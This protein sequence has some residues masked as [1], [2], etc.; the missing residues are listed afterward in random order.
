MKKVAIIGVGC[1]KFGVR[2]DVNVAELAFEAFKPS[3]EDA[4]ITPKEIEF[5]AVGSTGAGAWYEELLPAVVSAEYCGLTGAGLIRCEAACASGSAAFSTAYWAVASGQVE[6]AAALGIEKMRE[7][8]TPTMMEWIGRAGYYL[9][10]F[11]NFGL[12]FPA[13]YALYATAH[14]AKY[15]TTEEDLA[16]VAVKNHKYA[17]MNPIAHLQ[18]R[19]IVDDVL[20]S[21]VIAAPLKLFDCCPVSDGAASVILASEDKVKELKVDTPVWVAGVGFA[22]GTANM[23]KRLDYVGLEASVQASQKAYKMAKITPDQLDVAVVHDCFTIAEIMAYEDIGLCEKGEG[24]KL[25]REGQTEI[26]GKIPVN[27]DGGLKAKGHPIGT[28]G[29][30]M[31]YELTKQL[32]EEAIEKSRQVPMKNYIALAHNVGGTGHYCYVTILRR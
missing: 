2:N 8:D 26:G 30:A 19:I 3:V 24:A 29:C 11:H 27:V 12:T 16:L 32:R 10:E 5:V 18:N 13:Y 31:I 20:S 7:I 22:S 25:L 23:S 9:W 4:G 15:G 21:M 1:S 17:S 14:M 28:T 6:I